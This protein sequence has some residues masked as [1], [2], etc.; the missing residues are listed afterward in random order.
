VL[1]SASKVLEF[2]GT[3]PTILFSAHNVDLDDVKASGFRDLISKPFDVATVLAQI[4]T[5]LDEGTASA[6]TKVTRS[7]QR[8]R[9][10][11]E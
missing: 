8:N 10:A 5:L 1:T 11:D 7:R 3:A 4:R 6:S 9:P 2:A